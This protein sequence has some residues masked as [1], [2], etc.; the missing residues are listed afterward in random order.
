MK[1]ARWFLAH[2]KGDE[3]EDIDSWTQS[4][5]EAL[6][7]SDHTVEVVSGRDDYQE[8]AKALGG[9]KAWC[10]DVPHGRT[11]TGDAMFHGVIVPMDVGNGNPTVG[12]ATAVL[13]QG[14]L[15]EKKHV[16]TWCPRSEEF[17]KITGIVET[18]ANDWKG[19]ATLTFTP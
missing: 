18:D 14:F 17:N 9:W 16:F 13:L 6:N 19:W 15:D 1:L 11:Y 8:R 5:R 2:G 10:R 12:R 7:L 4:L 3:D